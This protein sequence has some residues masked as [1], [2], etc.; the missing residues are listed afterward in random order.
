[1]N[2][3]TVDP[4]YNVMRFCIETHMTYSEYLAQPARVMLRWRQMLAA[5]REGQEMARRIAD[6]QAKARTH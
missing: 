6:A 5:E 2:G 4:S 1:M 3:G